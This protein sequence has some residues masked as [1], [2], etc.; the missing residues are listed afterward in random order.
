MHCLSAVLA[1]ELVVK[2]ANKG[3]W[4]GQDYLRQRETEKVPH[5]LVVMFCAAA[6]PKPKTLSVRCSL[7]HEVEQ[8]LR[9]V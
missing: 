1:L 3:V 5:F 6:D 8:E 4:I 2:H 9:F 7:E